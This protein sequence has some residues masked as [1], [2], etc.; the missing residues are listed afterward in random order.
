MTLT[1]EKLHSNRWNW[2][3]GYDWFAE[4]KGNTQSVP[5][6]RVYKYTLKHPAMRCM[7]LM[8]ICETQLH[9]QSRITCKRPDSY[10]KI[11]P[12]SMLNSMC[13]VVVD[14][15]DVLLKLH[16]MLIKPAVMG[17]LMSFPPNA[18]Q[19]CNDNG[20]CVWNQNTKRLEKLYECVQFAHCP[21]QI[22]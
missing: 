11:L 14:R 2:S 6:L 15:M 8:L 16:F 21:Y 13:P 3:I 19:T 10:Q 18:A 17:K 12:V 22:I 4:K 7:Y 9:A 20:Y 1:S 5:P